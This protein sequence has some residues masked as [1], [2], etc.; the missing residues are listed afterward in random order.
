MEKETLEREKKMQKKQKEKERIA[1]QKADGTYMTKE[2]KEKQKRA[3][4]M[5]QQTGM[6][7]A[8][9]QDST[10]G[11]KKKK[12]LY[13][14]KKK[15]QRPQN[16]TEKEPKEQSLDA[17]DRKES[18]ESEDAGKLEEAGK[19]SSEDL[20]DDWEKVGGDSEEDESTE[21]GDSVDG[22][23][24]SH[25]PSLSTQSSV[26][27]SGTH[28]AAE[29]RKE[30]V[31]LAIEQRK[32]DNAK[33]RSKSELRAPIICVLGH[34]D[35]GKTSLLDKLRKSNVQGGEAGGITQQIGA[36]QVPI[37]IIRDKTK[38]VLGLDPASLT[39][40]GFLIID[41][42]GHESFGNLRSRGSSLCDIAILV[43]DIMHG[44]EP[45]TLESIRL[46]TAHKKKSKNI[47]F[48]VAL[49]K[50][51]R[52]YGWKADSNSDVRSVIEAQK[53]N[54]RK[55]FD[56]RVRVTVGMFAEQGLNAAL[57]WENPD[58]KEYINLVPTSAHSGDGMGNLM[59]YL[60]HFSHTHI[61][62][63]LAWSPELQCSVLE[64]K[65]L[66]GLGTTIDVILVNGELR[67]GD[68]III[69]G[70]EGPITTQIRDLMM[71]QPL[72]E[73]RV[74]TPYQHF[75]H[76]RAAQGVKIAGKE[77]EKA[78]AGLPLLVAAKE[79]E[80]EV[81]T[82][83]M[84]EVLASALQ[85]I[86]LSS[87]GVYVQA[88]TLGSLEALL[89]FLKGQ[90]IPYCGINIGPVHKKDVMKASTMLEQDAQYA[91]ILAFDVKVEREA[92][93]VADEMG[94]RIFTA[95]IIYHL[96]EAFLKYREELHQKEK[97][98][99]ASRVVYPCKLKIL[100]QYV[101]NKRDPII[102]GVRVESGVLRVGTP[103]VALTDEESKPFLGQISSIEQNN[104]PV[105]PGTDLRGTDVC[106][107]I[108]NTTGDAPK[109]IGRH[110]T[111]DHLLVS[112]IS[113]DSIDVA[114]Q[115]FRDDFTK[116]DWQLVIELKKLLAIL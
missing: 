58:P 5:L 10:G 27:T 87:V 42:P 111:E 86:K 96:E 4:A 30:R 47:P 28:E 18:P 61:P 48:V 54:T 17:V 66:P 12:P 14:N 69:A 89:E 101:F 107:K 51:D 59:G 88:S 31:R 91:V 77:L 19:S 53:P 1:R 83:E 36:T 52:L 85:A 97:A 106:I 20:A 32:I 38:M 16:S 103:I 40:P 3:Q 11:E 74:K 75:K 8:A 9:L 109:M 81:L 73:L 93:S 7:V 99:H 62:D 44:L 112:R 98:K 26:A 41:T 72:K 94:I 57:Y 55:E 82:E 6:V 113:R 78:L 105:E 67:Y 22:P 108:E 115:F 104:K 114:K 84:E 46:L 21:E 24:T 95:D 56:E 25:P 37:D 90:K 64:V 15:L 39:I 23:E 33:R 76:I 29:A 60:A 110:F 79:E 100:S 71:P 45:Q 92:A 68:T 116:A 80:V 65:Q 13:I 34:V 2:E 35:T 70:S 50:I 102:C 43:V 63:K 49:N